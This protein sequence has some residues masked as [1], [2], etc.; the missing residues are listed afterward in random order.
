MVLLNFAQGGFKQPQQLLTMT[1]FLALGQES[2]FIINLNGVN[3]IVLAHINH[4][5][6]LHAVMPSSHHLVRS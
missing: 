3:E 4:S 1:Y 5:R 2:D 6:G